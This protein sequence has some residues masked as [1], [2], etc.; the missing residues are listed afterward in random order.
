M[1]GPESYSASV[2]PSEKPVASDWGVRGIKNGMVYE[3]VAGDTQLDDEAIDLD[4]N[5][6]YHVRESRGSPDA[7][8]SSHKPHHRRQEPRSTAGLCGERGSA[9]TVG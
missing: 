7:R 4:R 5:C 3:A 1:K 6:V 2:G 8:G 9:R